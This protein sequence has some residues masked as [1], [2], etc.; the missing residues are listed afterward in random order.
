MTDG[1]AGIEG[2]VASDRVSRDPATCV[3]FSQDIAGAGPHAAAAV[4]RPG[5]VEDIQALVR[6][7]RGTGTPLIPRGGGMSYTGG[8]VP[9]APD[10]VMLDMTDIDAI[11]PAASHV[12]AGAGATWAAL[13]DRLAETGRRVPFFG[14]LSGI[15]ATIGGTLSQNGTFFGS[16]A[17][18]Y[19]GDQVLG[20]EVVDGRG[21]LVRLGASAFG[22]DAGLSVFGPT[23]QAMLVGDAGAF[24]IKTA[25][26]L[27]TCAVPVTTMFFSFA[28]Q[29]AD[30]VARAMAALCDLPHIADLWAFDRETHRNLARG[31]FSVLDATG[32]AADIAG[33]AGLRGAARALFD[34]ARFRSVRLEDL[35]WSLHGVVEVPVKGL[36]VPVLD[37]VAGA[38]SAQGGNALPDT[39]PRVTR[40]RPFRK[41]KA[42]VGP[43]GERWLPCHGIVPITRATEV[44]ARLDTWRARVQERLGQIRIATLLAVTGGEMVIEPQFFWPDSLSDF[45]RANAQPEQVAGHALPDDLATRETVHALR[46]EVTRLFDEAGAGHIQIGKYYRWVEDAEPATGALLRAFKAAMDPDGILNPGALGL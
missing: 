32:M 21:D 6:W 29:S 36:E 25:V 15:A 4:V 8:Y 14:P 24:G 9:S 22:R 26:V 33:A 44:L 43:D 31:G 40:A 34:A 12:H 7:A 39:I 35:A 17:H 16:T 13:H 38:V 10:A 3:L 1:A 46:A 30:D 18:G 2:I 5:S 41:I 42:L 11:Q 28:F 37:A 20:F 23:P 19:A 27:R 45:Q